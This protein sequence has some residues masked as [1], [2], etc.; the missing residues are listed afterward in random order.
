VLFAETTTA[1]M[2]IAGLL[3]QIFV[4][5]KRKTKKLKK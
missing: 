3:R 5:S 2:L 1:I 4:D